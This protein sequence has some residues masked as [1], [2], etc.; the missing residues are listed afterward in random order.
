MDCLSNIKT[1]TK[2]KTNTSIISA[3]QRICDLVSILLGWFFANIYD[4]E[5]ITQVSLLSII[6]LFQF[7][8]SI[9]NVYTTWRG[10]KLL[11]TV[12]RVGINCFLSFFVFFVVN[13]SFS[14]YSL[15]DLRVLAMWFLITLFFF[16]LF[17]FFIRCLCKYMRKKG[18]RVKKV[19]IFGKSENA[20]KLFNHFKNYPWLGFYVYGFYNNSSLKN[21][22]EYPIYY[23]GNE[24]NLMFDIGNGLVDHV[25]I[26]TDYYNEQEIK[27]LL[28]KLSN[29]TSSVH[30]IP[31]MIS[32]GL[33]QSANTDIEGIPI[34]P[35]YETSF[36]GMNMLLKRLIDIL[37]S[38]VL[39]VL[40]LPIMIL[41]YLSVMLTSPGS[42]IFKQKRYGL[43]GK[44]IN[45]FKFRTMHDSANGNNIRQ[46]TIDDS[47]VTKIGRILRR[48]SLDELPQ[49]FNVFLGSMSLVG[50]RPHAVAHNEE[51][52][53]LIHGYMLRHKVKPGITGWAQ[54]CGWRGET[55]T[56]DKMKKRIEYDFYYI[57]NWSV[58]FDV[59]ILFLTIIHGLWN[60]NAY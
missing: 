4:N 31:N 19:A 54:I 46:A 6:I 11:T 26:A 35:I 52:R 21:T 3:M 18:F 15:D 47:R 39:I 34:L 51:F 7:I 30:Y 53:K 16:S 45:V 1:K 49:L 22:S 38:F 9:N 24:N 48:T 5:M 59:K 56:L 28:F 10:E 40:F 33:L 58:M 29:T 44:E 14:K 55:D 37:L 27:S 60:K 12:Y 8:T 2:T 17:G 23:A 25:Y 50:P 32:Y 20:Y 57:N 36:N 43:D 42:V 13:F 41:T